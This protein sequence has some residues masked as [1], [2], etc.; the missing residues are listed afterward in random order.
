M[1]SDYD[2]WYDEQVK[3]DQRLNLYFGILSLILAMIGTVVAVI[4]LKNMF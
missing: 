2:D 1:N 3:L 4:F